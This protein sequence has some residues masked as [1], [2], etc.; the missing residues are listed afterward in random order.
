MASNTIVAGRV[1]Q[2]KKHIWVALTGI[3]G[4]GKTRAVKICMDVGIEASTKV[5]DLSDDQLDEIRSKVSDFT[6]EGDLRR[7]IRLNIKRLMDIG[8]YRGKRHRRGLPVNG[9]NTKNNAR[10]R[11]GRRKGTKG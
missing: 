7:E 10:T 8:C 6:I 9:Q 1:L 11:K 5:N 3:Y 2:P 4:I